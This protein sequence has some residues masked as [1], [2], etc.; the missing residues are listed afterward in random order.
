MIILNPVV[1]LLVNFSVIGVLWYGGYL[2]QDGL[3]ETGKIMAFINYLT[4]IMMSMMMVIMISMNFSR[5]KASA[6]RINEVFATNSSIQENE[7]TAELTNYD[8]EF[9]N[10]SF[11]YHE[12]SEEVLKDIS[13][14]I[15][16]G[17][18]VG[19]IGGTGSGKVH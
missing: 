19:I 4:Q 12:H 3:L 14:K 5:A 17:N 8:I 7:K 16:Q 11:K 1:M 13:F 10:V 18:Q 9:K 15:K 6:D 2:V